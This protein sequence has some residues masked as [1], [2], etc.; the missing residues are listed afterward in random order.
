MSLRDK[1][2][3]EHKTLAP[4]EFT[5]STGE[6]VYIRRFNGVQRG[7]WD[8]F[9][10][11]AFDEDGHLKY[12]GQYRARLAQLSLCEA[13]GSLAFQAGDI[14]LV[15]SLNGGFLEEVYLESARVNL[16]SQW[17]VAKARENFL[18]TRAKDSSTGSPGN[19]A[20]PTPS[21]S[22]TN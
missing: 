22:A 8:T 18:A 5:A 10:A 17:E 9:N 2:L 13:D 14:A 1:L 15:M 6:R 11:A 20:N 21:S 16:L 19:A 4:V 12:P 3:A 7:E